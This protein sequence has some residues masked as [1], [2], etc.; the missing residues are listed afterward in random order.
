M[1]GAANVCEGG[2]VEGSWVGDVLRDRLGF[3]R[4]DASW[5]GL[6]RTTR[7]PKDQAVPVSFDY[8]VGSGEQ[9]Q[10]NVDPQSPGGLEID[11]RDEL[12]RVFDRKVAGMRALE[13][14][15]TKSAMRSP[16]SKTSKE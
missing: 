8:L 1:P 2:V 16:A 6:A 13:D 10:R 14:L 11:D 9:G 12:G 3:E 5:D 7:A 4:D 15:S